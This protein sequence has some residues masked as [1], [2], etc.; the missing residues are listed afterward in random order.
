MKE[1]IL[2]A[3][4]N[5]P[6]RKFIL[7]S[8]KSAGYTV[9]EAP[10]GKEALNTIKNE[11][12]DL[13]LLDLDLGDMSGLEIIK[14]IRTQNNETPIIVV[15]NFEQVDTKVNAFNIGCD[16]YI[17]KPFYK[18]ELLARVS[19]TCEKITKNNLLQILETLTIPPFSIDYRKGVIFKNNIALDLNKKMF[20]VLSYFIVNRNNIISKDQLLTR[21]WSNTTDPSDNTLSVHIHMIREKIEDKSGK[22]SYLITKRGL[23]YCF[24][25]IEPN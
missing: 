9:L 20:D 21:F 18:E 8:L 6:L 2:V 5:N 24:N 11:F 10:N 15:S 14:I 25:L 22:P 19:R 23:G 17:T 12:V 3:E 13:I 7:K 4:D 1:T 16:D